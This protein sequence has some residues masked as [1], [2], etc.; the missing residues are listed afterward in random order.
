[1]LLLLPLL[2]QAE[3]VNHCYDQT[4]KK[5]VFT[6]MPCEKLGLILRTRVDGLKMSSADGLPRTNYVDQNGKFIANRPVGWY[7]APQSAGSVGPLEQPVDFEK[8]QL[9]RRI[10]LNIDASDKAKSPQAAEYR[11]QWNK[12]G[13][14]L[15]NLKL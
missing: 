7:E 9:C 1:M 14:Y 6:D 15:L 11:Y 5:S 13:C 12:N 3:T 2:V 8:K 4:K 10:R